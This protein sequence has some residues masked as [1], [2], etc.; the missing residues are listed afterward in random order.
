MRRILLIILF[1]LFT[2]AAE[3]YQ[4]YSFEMTAYAPLD[5]RAQEGVCYS[6]NKYVTASGKR[7][8]PCIS[9]A[10]DKSIP[11]GTWIYIF[12]IGLRRVDDRGGNI[13]GRRIDLCVNTQKE[14]FRIGRRNVLV[15]ILD[16]PNDRKAFISLMKKKET[17]KR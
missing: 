4:I 9:V 16:N 17:L 7:T 3:G 12:G 15:W 6:G 10:M 14:A 8:T 5:T 11:F 13:V 2:G 1:L